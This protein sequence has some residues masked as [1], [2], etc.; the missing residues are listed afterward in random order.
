[1]LKSI[2]CGMT[3][4]SLLALTGCGTPV[5][6]VADPVDVIIK[7]TV[8]GKPLNNVQ[9]TLQPMID[10][11]QSQGLVDKGVYKASVVPG[12]YTYY[13]DSG[14]SEADLAKIPDGYRMGSKDRSLE[15]TQGGTFEVDIN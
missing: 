14:K 4:V 3:L 8:A 1:M 12:V 9:L 6:S 11:A 7:V 2:K 5:N 13:I 15:L 10:G